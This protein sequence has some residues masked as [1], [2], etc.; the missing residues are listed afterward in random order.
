VV[1]ERYEL[2][3]FAL[4]ERTNSRRR[5]LRPNCVTGPLRN[6]VHGRLA[7]AVDTRMSVG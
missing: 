3:L 5:A 7:K 4:G 1:H 2:C 6:A